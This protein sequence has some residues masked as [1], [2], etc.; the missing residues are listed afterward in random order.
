M[1]SVSDMTTTHKVTLAVAV[2]VLA[3][4]LYFAV[5]LSFRSGDENCQNVVGSDPP[6]ACESP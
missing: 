1:E 5:V 4:A 6:Q 2:I 3:I